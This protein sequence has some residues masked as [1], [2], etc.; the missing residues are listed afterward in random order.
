MPLTLKADRRVLGPRPRDGHGGALVAAL[1]TKA[2]GV[3][4][5]KPVRDL[6]AEVVDDLMCSD[7]A[8]QT[9]RVLARR[10]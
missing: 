8:E 7:A 4:L 6:P 2:R 1:A 5:A 3:C 10:N 9:V